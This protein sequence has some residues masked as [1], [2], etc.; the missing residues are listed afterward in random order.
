MSG[1]KWGFEVVPSIENGMPPL[2]LPIAATFVSS[3]TIAA[4]EVR[5]H[6]E[7]QRT[8]RTH[9]SRSGDDADRGNREVNVVRF[10]SFRGHA[11]GEADI[12]DGGI[13]SRNRLASKRRQPS[14]FRSQVE[15]RQLGVG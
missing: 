5:Q 7:I 14:Q 6:L 3:P 8:L 10:G 12:L 1:M 15:P 4:F 9:R 2:L 13:G 11:R